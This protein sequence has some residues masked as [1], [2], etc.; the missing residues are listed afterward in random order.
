MGRLGSEQDYLET[1]DLPSGRM[2]GLTSD[3]C[4]IARESREPSSD[5]KANDG[6]GWW[7]PPP[8]AAR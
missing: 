7:G 1:P 5:G 2:L 3:R 4:F 6:F 8:S